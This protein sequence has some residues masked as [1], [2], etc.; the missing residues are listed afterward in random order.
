MGMGKYYARPVGDGNRTFR[1]QT[2]SWSVKSRASQLAETFDL[3]CA[4]NNCYK[5]ALR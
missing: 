4:V 1:R 3:K 5:C 2:N